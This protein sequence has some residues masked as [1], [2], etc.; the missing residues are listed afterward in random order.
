MTTSK[1]KTSSTHWPNPRKLWKIKAV[2]AQL[3]SQSKVI[4]KNLR[5]VEAV[6]FTGTRYLPLAPHALSKPRLR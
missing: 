3:I 6:S 1:K 2:T 5:A 4:A